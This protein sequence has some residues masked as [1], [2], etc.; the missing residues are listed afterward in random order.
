MSDQHKPGFT[1]REI[2]RRAIIIAGV[3]AATSS[4]ALLSGCAMTAPRSAAAKTTAFS[5]ADIAWLDEVAETIL[6]AT[7]TP[8]AKAA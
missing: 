6:P 1:R 2:V 3:S 7:S 5:S 8:G 4:A